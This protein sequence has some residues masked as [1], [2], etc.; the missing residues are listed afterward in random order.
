MQ[1]MSILLTSMFSVWITEAQA[2]CNTTGYRPRDGKNP[3]LCAL[4]Y[5]LCQLLP[6][7][8]IPVFIFA[9]SAHP[10]GSVPTTSYR[11]TQYFQ[12]FIEAFGFYWY[13]VCF[14]SS[15]SC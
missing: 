1:T 10:T 13:K 5:R 15:V 12:A 11:V 3:V 4:F 9:S 2:L 8:V 14:L 6:L 7:P